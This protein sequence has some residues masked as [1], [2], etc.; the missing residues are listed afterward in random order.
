MKNG[1]VDIVLTGTDT[2][3][4][5]IGKKGRDLVLSFE[6]SMPLEPTC[7]LKVTFPEE[8]KLNIDETVAVVKGTGGF[9]DGANVLVSVSPYG[10]GGNYAILTGCASVST[11]Y[12][13]TT[14]LT[15]Q[16]IVSPGQIKE[17]S[18]I[19]VELATDAGITKILATGTN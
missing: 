5:H 15:F 1:A 3:D 16:K 2:S 9:M 10:S 7:F 12:I 19:K 4:Y 6:V 18:G 8:I 14:V 11:G 17:V 13:Q